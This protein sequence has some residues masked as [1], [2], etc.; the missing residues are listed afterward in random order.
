MGF[1]Q[2]ERDGL[3]YFAAESLS[4]QKGFVHGFSTRLGGVSTGHLASLNLRG[5]APSGDSREHVEEN[6]RR[7]CRALDLPAERMVLS[8]QVHTDQVRLV[9]EADAGKGLWCPRDYDADALITNVPGLPLA[10]FSA[11]C[12]VILLFDPVGRAMGAVHSGWRGTALGILRK[13]VEEMNRA[14]G[15]EPGNLLA[16][17]GPGIGTCCF[18]THD[19]VPQA[20]R[21]ALGDAADA[22]IAPRGEKWTVDLKGINRLWLERTGVPSGRIEISPLC[23]ACR[24]DLFWSHRRM[25]NARGVQC[26]VG[27]LR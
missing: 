24:T 26:A 7:L 20:M 15:T 2:R 21:Q 27:A 22:F 9:T 11:D 8:H 23:T 4:A 16:A 6:Y 1:V 19:D 17:I 10:V 14:F 13:T 5:S 12:I 18:E 25:G 3:V